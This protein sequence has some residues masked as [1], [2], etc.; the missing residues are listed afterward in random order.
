MC[1]LKAKKFP[2]KHILQQQKITSL[3]EQLQTFT[4]MIANE[5]QSSASNLQEIEKYKII[6][7][8]EKSGSSAKISALDRTIVSLNAKNDGLIESNKKFESRIADLETLLAKS[9]QEIER[10]RTEN[11]TNTREA[12]VKIENLSSNIQYPF[13]C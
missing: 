10:L 6:L 2:T 9:G 5:K 1:I 7:E 4:A 8:N 13:V 11:E 3:N 12:A